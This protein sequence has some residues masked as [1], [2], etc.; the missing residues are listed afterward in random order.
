M[1]TKITD[2]GNGDNLSKV[3]NLVNLGPGWSKFN[4]GPTREVMGVSGGD[5]QTWGEWLEIDE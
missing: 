4:D 2:G 5:G 1:A 3:L